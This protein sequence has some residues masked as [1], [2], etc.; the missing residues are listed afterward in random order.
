MARKAKKVK[1]IKGNKSPWGIQ[2][3]LIVLFTS[4]G[5]CSIIAV[6]LILSIIKTKPVQASSNTLI[7]VAQSAGHQGIGQINNRDLIQTSDGTLHTFVQTYAVNNNCPA[8]PKGQLNGLM[9]FTSTN[10]GTTW[11]CSGY[12]QSLLQGAYTFPSAV[13]DSSDNIYLVYSLL[14]YQATGVAFRKLTKTGSTWTI[15]PEQVAL[16][17]IQ[18]QIGYAQAVLSIDSANR[19]WMAVQTTNK[20]NNTIT[21]DAYYASD[22]T[23]TPTWTHSMT[24]SSQPATSSLASIPVIVHFG[25][26]I[27]II[28]STSTP[29]FVW[30]YR[31]DTDDPNTWSSESQITT[32]QNIDPDFQAVADNAGNVHFVFSLTGES[33]GSQIQY[34]YYNSSTSNWSSQVNMDG[35]ILANAY[36]SITTDGTNVYVFY[37]SRPVSANAHQICFGSNCPPV[38]GMGFSSTAL[39]TYAYR[40]GTPP[41]AANNF[42]SPK[43]VNPEDG[44]FNRIYTQSGSTSAYVDQTA[45]TCAITTPIVSKSNDV[46]YFGGTQ[47]YRAITGIMQTAGVGGTVV[48]EYWNGTAWAPLSN[49]ESSYNPNFTSNRAYGYG[50]MFTP[51]SDWQ[52]TVLDT[53]NAPGSYYYIRARVTTP[54]T[55]AP[56][57]RCFW[58]FPDG[59]MIQLPLMVSNNI[60]P[61]MWPEVPYGQGNSHIRF[62]LLPITQ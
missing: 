58:N 53:T 34:M 28:Y 41:F 16:P 51:P 3:H 32:T 49:P 59:S 55:T 13:I 31:N 56:T 33:S 37:G 6:G 17:Y 24:L 12:I 57:N 26:K 22:L 25:N 7:N 42:S 35:G 8:A 19:L 18:G 23:S 47:P 52:Q 61:L 10:N 15:G 5:I 62:S 36:P 54:Y 48:Y 1:K 44:L 30:R 43:L 2:K 20:T 4:I 46:I 38:Q 39:G 11:Q 29:A 45:L 14:N 40:I 60:I 9:W 50:L 21:A 27:G